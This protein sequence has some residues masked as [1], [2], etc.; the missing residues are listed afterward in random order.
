M[1]LRTPHDRNDLRIKKRDY[2]LEVGPGHR[3]NFRSDVIAEKFIDSNYHR[4]DE[5]KMYAHQKFVHAAGENL[6]F[7][8]NEFD[9]VICC[10][11]LEHADDPAR[12]ITEQTRVA[13]RGYMET[14]SAIGEMLFPKKSHRWA[15]LEIDGKLVIFDKSQMEST[16]KPDFGN[17][18]LDYLPYKSLAFRILS[19]THADIKSIR[20]EWKDSIDF[21][22]NPEDEYYR[23]FFTQRWTREMMEKIF[24]ARPFH[25]EFFAVC[26]AI[27]YILKNTL[28]QKL[29]RRPQPEEVKEHMRLK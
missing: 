19:Y 20:Y 18:F 14:P 1:K 21:L 23:S 13:K 9:Y 6:P 22:V 11:V 28:K 10:Q 2:V 26:G 3:P 27:V 5:A 25:K 12:F 7:R 15:I 16:F 4:N 8:D 24:P 17:L 29:S